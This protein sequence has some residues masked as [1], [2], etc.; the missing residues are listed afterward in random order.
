MYHTPQELEA[1]GL[2]KI[3][4]Q[5]EATP[6]WDKHTSAMDVVAN[7]LWEKHTIVM[8]VV[9]NAFWAFVYFG[10]PIVLR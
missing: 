1:A 8:A 6:C 2:L 9:A 4:E 5:P 10:L 3:V 7:I